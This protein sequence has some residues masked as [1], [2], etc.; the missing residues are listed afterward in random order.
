MSAL[1]PMSN[2]WDFPLQ[3]EPI[4]VVT[5]VIPLQLSFWDQLVKNGKVKANLCLLPFT[6]AKFSEKQT[7][8]ARKKKVQIL[9]AVLVNSQDVVKGEN[10][11]TALEITMKH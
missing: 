11:F 4:K 2:E 7:E 9:P 1:L 8:L 5:L 6:S 10:L 3:Y